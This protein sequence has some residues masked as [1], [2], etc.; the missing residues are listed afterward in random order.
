MITGSAF[1]FKI[2]AILVW[3]YALRLLASA[4]SKYSPLTS[5][6]L[7]LHFDSLAPESH[8]GFDESTLCFVNWTKWD[9]VLGGFGN[10]EEFRFVC[11]TNLDRD[12]FYEPY[13]PCAQFPP[14][15]LGGLRSNVEEKLP[16]LRRKNVA[17]RFD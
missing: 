13:E 8:F 10:L 5:I 4:L 17:V 16:S 2:H 12:A 14:R 3:R 7:G 9:E 15:M 6:S 11:M 1:W